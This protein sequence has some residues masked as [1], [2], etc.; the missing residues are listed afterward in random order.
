MAIFG[1]I[2]VFLLIGLRVTSNP[3]RICFCYTGVFGMNFKTPL[4]DDTEPFA[5]CM[6]VYYSIAIAG[7]VYVVNPVCDT[8]CSSSTSPTSQVSLGWTSRPLFDDTE[9]FGFDEGTILEYIYITYYSIACTSCF[10]IYDASFTP[11]RLRLNRH[12]SCFVVQACLGWTS[13][14]RCLMTLRPLLWLHVLL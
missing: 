12:R 8:S 2:Y 4:F 3:N 13:R 9:P 11:W 7:V 5:M 14:L 10:Y 1:L 6:Y